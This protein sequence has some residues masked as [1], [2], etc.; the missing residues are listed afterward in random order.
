[1]K[2][3]DE[4]AWITYDK[5]SKATRIPPEEEVLV[6]LRTPFKD[7]TG[8]PVFYCTRAKR[9]TPNRMV[10]VK[11]PKHQTPKYFDVCCVV[12]WARVDDVCS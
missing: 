6:E 7:T 4:Y 8:K 10:I 2:R 3:L 1:M 5:G 11:Q 9:I 12:R